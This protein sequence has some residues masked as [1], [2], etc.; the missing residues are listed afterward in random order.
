MEGSSS[1]S[2]AEGGSSKK[3]FA[4]FAV[5]IV[6]A[7]V[8]IAAFLL[9]PKATKEKNIVVAAIDGNPSSLDP[10]VDY[11]TV[12]GEIIQNVY[13]TLMFYDG[14][15][16]STLVPFLC[17]A[18]PTVANGLVSADGYNYT[19]NLR[20]GV[21][22]H[23]GT[24]LTSADV[25]YSFERVL[26][27]ND[28]DGP[29]W[30]VGEML[31]PNY[32]SYD[33]GTFGSDGV[34]NADT[35]V[36][37][38]VIAQHIWAK[39]PTMVQFNLSVAFPGWNFIIT[40]GVG[41]IVSKAFVEANG[42]MSKAGYDFMAT[43]MCGTGAFTLKEYVPS[44]HFLMVRNDNYWRTP[45]QINSV[46][47]KQVPDDNTK[48]LEIKSGE[49]DFAQIPR[50]LRSGLDG[51]SNLRIGEGNGTFN[52]DFL[53][54]NEKITVNS[55]TTTVPSTFFADKNVRLAFAHAF[56]E[57]TFLITQFNGS[58]IQPNGCIPKGMFGYDSSVP[59]YDFNIS[60]VR[61]YLKNATTTIDGVETNWLDAGFSIEIYYNSGNS[62][63]QTA[64][65][66][67]KDGLEA[68][69]SNIHV[70]VTGLEWATYL[71]A[72]KKGE[73]PVMFLGWAPDYAD[74]QDYVA[75]FYQSAGTYA[76]MVGY[77]NHTLDQAIEDAAS[78][79]NPTQRAALYSNMM[80]DMQKECV[81]VWT[82]QATNFHVE[83][84]W[85]SGY[86][87]NPMYSG[88]YYYPMDKAV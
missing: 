46:L 47:I 65:E 14:T 67:F 8:V 15:S 12:G 75:P 18:V 17:T 23:D 76:H 61:A 84:T 81:F 58:G 1:G 22:F 41:S 43:A 5:V 6:V 54:L 78:E 52:I 83:R 53:G 48:I 3:M 33:A 64:C 32:Y 10:A 4:I 66:L 25:Y 82:V 69:S 62:V 72:R 55:T 29:A 30:M 11:E 24:T 77:V 20:E 45:S 13:E 42:G 56:N 88:L 63:R 28:P 34:L 9:M 26:R 27:L 16:A 19:Y 86:Q 79:L 87:F 21:K 31:I 44:D 59:T 60:A 57:Q 85:I 37:A 70:T 2:S 39:T 74:P 40:F 38:D 50:A 73:L 7:A 80:Y 51:D 71:D 49:A 36:P 35:G 68:A